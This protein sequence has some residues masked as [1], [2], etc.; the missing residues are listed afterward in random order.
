[1]ERTI[2]ELTFFFFRRLKRNAQPRTK[3]LIIP[4][5]TIVIIRDDI[6]DLVSFHNFQYPD[7]GPPQTFS[8]HFFRKN[9]RLEIVKQ[10]ERKKIKGT[11]FDII[12][13]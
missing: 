10:H 9:Y 7:K 3:I 4:S 13:I 8:G 6:I 12:I 1:M 11:K 5:Q 2:N